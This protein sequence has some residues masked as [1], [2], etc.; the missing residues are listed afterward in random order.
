[1]KLIDSKGR[2]FNT[3]SILDLGAALVILLVIIGIFFF[4]GTSGSV[5]QVS[6]TKPIEMDVLIQGLRIENP[7][8]LKSELEEK[9]TTQLIIRNQPHGQVNVQA[10][11]LIPKTVSVPQPDGSVIAKPDPRPEERFAT[12]WLITLGG[13]A[14]I[15]DSGAV[16][17]N[18]K[19]KIGTT[20]ELEGFSYNFRGS[21]VEIRLPEEG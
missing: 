5:A 9:K 11:E 17:G 16:L 7:K 6:G 14:K 13:E 1:M 18:N 21:I 8:T 2:L 3:I 19:I 10:V 12:D 15:T 20:V 4:P